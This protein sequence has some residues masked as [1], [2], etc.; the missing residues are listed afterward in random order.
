MSMLPKILASCCFAL[1]LG[2]VARAEDAAQNEPYRNPDN[3]LCRPGRADLCSGNLSSTIV[4]PDGSRRR[5]PWAPDPAAP[6]DCFYVY[7]TVSQE[8]GG[9]SSMTPGAGE[10]GAVEQQFG[11][12]AAVCRPF[13]PMYRQVTVAGLRSILE[14]HPMPV[15]QQLAERDVLAAWNDYMKYD[16]HGRGVVLIGHS[17]G[18]RRLLELLKREIDG[19]PVQAQLVSAMLLGVPV[20]VPVGADMGGSLRHIPYCHDGRQTGCVLSYASFR[21]SSPPQADAHFGRNVHAGME[22]V[23]VDPVLLS[24]LPLLSYLPARSRA[25][26]MGGQIAEWNKSLVGLD[27]PFVTLPGLLSGRCVKDGQGAYFAISLHPGP[28]D[29]RPADIPGDLIYNGKVLASWGLH[30]L[31]VGLAEGNL[32]ALVRQQGAAYL[33]RPASRLQP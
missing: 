26:A 24:G 8:A 28:A 22:V 13:A 9:N 15:D 27:T 16:N 18:A 12:F 3:W 32:E 5:E 23:C 10:R 4:A 2:D 31:D 11:R 1:L 7:P 14:L 17:Q 25:L 33:S 29:A 20:E 19:K 30:L 6:I 21:A